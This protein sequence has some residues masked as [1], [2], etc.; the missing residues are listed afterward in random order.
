MCVGAYK[1]EQ[2]TDSFYT[3]TDKE[4]VKKVTQKGKTLCGGGFFFFC[5]CLRAARRRVGGLTAFAQLGLFSFG[6]AGFLLGAGDDVDDDAAVVFA[7]LRA[8][9][10][11]DSERAAFTRGEAAGLDSM[12]RTPLGGLGTVATHSDYHK[13]PIIQI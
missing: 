13:R 10:V 8:R 4:Q 9:T 6:A 5:P 1:K 2:R 12:M 11:G 3:E 7:A